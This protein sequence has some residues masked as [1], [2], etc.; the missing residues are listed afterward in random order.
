M[1]VPHRLVT[2]LENSRSQTLR[3]L[4]KKLIEENQQIRETG[5]TPFVVG[6][7]TTVV[8]HEQI[9]EILASDSRFKDKYLLV[10]P[11]ELSNLIE[12][13][14]QDH[15]IRQGLLQKSD[16]VFSSNPS[17]AR[18]CLGR[19]PYKEGE[20]AFINEFKS[21]K[22]CIHGSDA[23]SL[24]VIGRPCAKRGEQ[25]HKCSVE[26]HDCEMRF[27]WIKADPTFEGLKQLKYEPADRVRI[28]ASDPSPLKSN[29]CITGFEA[30]GSSINEELSLAPTKLQ[31]NTGLVAVIGG[32]GA[33]KTALVDLV[34]NFFIDRCNTS[35]PNSFV[36][37]IV[38]DS[39]NFK[40]VITFKE[41]TAF[42]KML[43][44]S[45]YVENSEIVY[46]AQGELEQYIG[47]DS[48]LDKY[49][50]GVIFESP[51]VRNTVK[52][53]EFEELAKKIREFEQRIG[54]AHQLIEKLETRT[55]EKVLAGAKREKSQIEAEVKDVES[56]IPAL[57]AQLTKE[58]V[59][60]IKSKQMA[61]STLQSRKSR[62]LEFG[63][64]LTNAKQFLSIDLVRF[65]TYVSQINGLLRELAIEGT[66]PSVEYGAEQK[67]A[68]IQRNVET[69]LRRVV[70]QIEASEKELRGYEAE[71]R[72]HAKYL[73]RRNELS[74][75][76][77]SVRQKLEAIATDSGRLGKAQE[78]RNNLFADLLRA[79]LEQRRKYAEI[80]ELFG[81]QKADVLSDLD[82]AANVE[83]DRTTLLRGLQ[84]ILDNR[85]VEVF[86]DERV[87]SEFEE[88]QKLYREV[89]S[90]KEAAIDGLV[91]ETAGLCEG[92]KGKIKPSQ[93]I[94]VGDLYKCLFGTYLSV[95]PVV[96]YKKTP[97]NRLSLGQKATVLIKLYLAQGTNPIIIDSHDDYLDNEF[98][99][100]ELVG[101]IRQAKT[102]RQVILASNNG[103][104]VIN[105]DAEQLVVAHREKGVISYYSGSIEN[106]TIRDR[107]L[108][109][110]EGG[111]AAFKKRQEKYRIGP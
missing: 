36:R 39:A 97:L 13:G 41:G 82:F 1:K 25:G 50:R 96:T 62:L 14:K 34:A 60:V 76:L 28:Q 56:K 87:K 85:Q 80:I 73:S 55:A 105:S 10:F 89:A 48:D 90:G 38:H 26:A 93:A 53:F 78:E 8:N 111:A 20:A 49:V 94:S 92:M 24:E 4:E 65:N 61:R 42:D 59:A 54:Q 84:D 102:Y 2:R 67:L 47:E 72:E 46:I 109:V 21:L 69:E 23:H 29:Y 77:A 16:M 88:L 70:G 83:F 57:E 30:V 32:K 37:R 79:V 22:P 98:I 99:M 33:G 71:M 66:L 103:N 17:A 15:I 68:G 101:A 43:T 81:S 12:W 106:P 31:F 35:D 64:L 110:L 9:A 75:R 7:R 51:Q 104:V 11:D 100:D 27:C 18:W 40:T 86:G 63:E 6:A 74:T 44:D 45:R 52:A 19:G 91:Q 108:Q 5:E 58:K 107:A 3:L 95:L